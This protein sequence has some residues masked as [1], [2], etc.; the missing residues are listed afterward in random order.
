MEAKLEL[1]SA[2]TKIEC[3]GVE[4]AGK[5]RAQAIDQNRDEELRAL[6][7]ELGRATRDLKLERE[8]RA[9]E[10]DSL[11]KQNAFIR[12]ELASENARMRKEA[13]SMRRVVSQ[14][15]QD[16]SFM[17]E[18]LCSERAPDASPNEDTP[19]GFEASLAL[20]AEQADRDMKAALEFED[21]YIDA[22]M[23]CECYAER[24]GAMEIAL[25]LMFE[26]IPD[27]AAAPTIDRFF[28]GFCANNLHVVTST[29]PRRSPGKITKANLGKIKSPVVKQISSSDSTM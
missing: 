5:E 21:R 15:S 22:A 13:K 2:L 18:E 9:I 19:A 17:E 26:Q 6:R 4:A 1:A 14:M 28:E 10:V 24:L 27:E 8:E 25:Q 3:A 7:D 11:V 29:S 23:E 16:L 20:V 12:S